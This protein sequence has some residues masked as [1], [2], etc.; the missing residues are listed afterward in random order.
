[1]PLHHHQADEKWAWE[2]LCYDG[3]CDLPTGEEEVTYGHFRRLPPTSTSLYRNDSLTS[4]LSDRVLSKTPSL[5]W[6]SKTSRRPAEH[7]MLPQPML[8]CQIRK[9]FIKFTLY[10]HHPST[11]L[12]L[13]SSQGQ[14]AAAAL[15]WKMD[16]KV[17]K[18]RRKCSNFPQLFQLPTSDYLLFFWDLFQIGIS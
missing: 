7:Q 12:R 16:Q 5:L 14:V 3:W 17:Q 8:R 10:H 15:W 2:S 11:F 9:F 18:M 4:S 13:P 1:M 6:L